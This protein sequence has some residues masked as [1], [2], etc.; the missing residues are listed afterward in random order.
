MKRIFCMAAVFALAASLASAGEDGGNLPGERIRIRI[1]IE[2]S[3]RLRSPRGYT[4]Y[5]LRGVKRIAET[6]S[7]LELENE[8]KLVYRNRLYFNYDYFLRRAGESSLPEITPGD[9]LLRTAGADGFLLHHEL[10]EAMYEEHMRRMFF[11]VDIPPYHR[12]TAYRKIPWISNRTGLFFGNA[13][14]KN[15]NVVDRA[16]QTVY[17]S[18]A[19]D[20]NTQMRRVER[21]GQK[22]ANPQAVVLAR[23]ERTGANEQWRRAWGWNNYYFF[24]GEHIYLY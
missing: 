18:A 1:Q 15:S 14:W 12:K 20:F 5:D 17:G 9:F 21:R 22:G 11:I 2:I 4:L 23:L 19:D 6:R 16:Y 13:F 24:V 3:Q 8:K 7:P 10:L